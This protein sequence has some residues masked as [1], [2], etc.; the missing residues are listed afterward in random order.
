VTR[1]GPRNR[2][3]HAPRLAEGEIGDAR[4]RHHDSVVETD[5]ADALEL[6]MRQHASAIAAAADSEV[7]EPRG[8]TMMPLS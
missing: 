8:T 6:L 4:L 1:I 3:R 5:L 7:P 2:S